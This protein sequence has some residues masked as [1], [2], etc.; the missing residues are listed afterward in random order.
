MWYKHEINANHWTLEKDTAMKLIIFK[1]IKQTWILHIHFLNILIKV[2]NVK[3]NSINL[4]EDQ[5]TTK[6]QMQNSNSRN[7]NKG[8][9][10]CPNITDKTNPQFLLNHSDHNTKLNTWN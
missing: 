9:N 4:D 6:K 10:N 1:P 5:A 7:S 8:W 3:Y 2:V